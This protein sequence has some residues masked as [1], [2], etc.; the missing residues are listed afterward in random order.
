MTSAGTKVVVIGGDAVIGAALEALLE[1]TG[2]RVQF[3]P[4]FAMD[5]LGASLADAQLLIVVPTLSLQRW[6]AVLKLT[7]SP[8]SARIPVLQLLPTNGKEQR[9]RG[10]AVP[11][12]CRVEELKRAIDHAL[13]AQQ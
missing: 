10:Y 5:E 11:W 1:S 9:I 13:L 3:L 7:S 8:L 4:E 12:P 2:Y 6:Q